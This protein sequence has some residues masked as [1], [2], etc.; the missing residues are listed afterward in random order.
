[1]GV[2]TVHVVDDADPQQY[3]DFHCEVKLLISHMQYFTPYVQHLPGQ[4]VELTVKCSLQTF[5]WLIVS[6][7]QRSARIQRH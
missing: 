5:G 3:H 6:F 4:D 1:M 2:V 7:Q